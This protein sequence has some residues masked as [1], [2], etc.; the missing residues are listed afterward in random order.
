MITREGTSKGV[1]FRLYQESDRAICLD[2][3][4]TNQPDYFNADDFHDFGEWLSTGQMNTYWMILIDSQPIGCGGIFI[5]EEKKE[6]GLAWGMINRLHHGQGYGTELTLFRLR[7]LTKRVSFPVKLCTSQH[8]FKFYEGLG[9]TVDKVTPKG[10][11]E[12]LDRY[13]MLWSQ[14]RDNQDAAK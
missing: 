11:D 14:N 5:N 2:L 12:N 6:A 9:F 4:K 8:T 3:L 13:D 1:H 7:E 10:F